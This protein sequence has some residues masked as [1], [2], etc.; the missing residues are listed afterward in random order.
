VKGRLSPGDRFVQDETIEKIIPGSGP[1]SLTARVRG[2]NPGSWVVTARVQGSTQP[3]RGAKVQANVTDV[4]AGSQP[5]VARIWR[6]WAPSVESDEHMKTCLPPF[7][8]VPG[9]LPGI[10]GTMVTLGM[11][12]ALALQ[13]LV[14]AADHLA[15]GPWWVVTL[16]AIAVGIVGA[17]V[18][19]IILQRREHRI[20]GWCIQGFIVSAPLAAAIVLAVLHVAVGV[21]L[22][23]TAPGLLV[24]MAV[25]RVGCFFAGCCGGP[26]TASRWG[27]WSSDQR[28]GARRIPTQ[29]LESVLALSLGLLVLVAILNRGPAGGA[30]FVAA[31]AAY[32]LG[33][34][35]LLRL[36]AEPRKTRLGGL[37]TATL[38]AL[39]LV[40]AVVWLAR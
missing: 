34:Q 22:D 26:P 36:R 16:V 23:V 30:F 27:V 6:K 19:F 40:A 38:A 25:G 11:A 29:L 3:A 32:T 35:G 20:E 9:I 13:A 2:I 7:A 4:S 21:F 39:V 14:I 8:R 37:V 12:V 28:M 5:E 15:L 18:W 1:I 17:K 33:R 31:L 10:W 24:A